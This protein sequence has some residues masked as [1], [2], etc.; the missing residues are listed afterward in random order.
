MPEFGPLWWWDFCPPNPSKPIISLGGQRESSATE[1]K[2]CF[3]GGAT[4]CGGI[5][6]L[7]PLGI[8]MWEKKTLW[9]TEIK[10]IFPGHLLLLSSDKGDQVITLTIATGPDWSCQHNSHLFWRRYE[11]T[12]DTDQYVRVR[13]CQPWVT[14]CSWMRDCKIPIC[15]I[16][17][18]V[19]ESLD[20]LL[21]SLY[22]W[23]SPCGCLLRHVIAVLREKWVY[24][25]WSGSKSL[26]NLHLI[27]LLIY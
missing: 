5:T 20:S 6:L 8:S 18:P 21:S 26:D 25:I 3:S 9:P 14:L 4:C 11:P 23:E 22:H 7:V 13:K 24:A 10:S 19:L 2:E 27:L 12:W 17:P 1:Y 16:F 15:C